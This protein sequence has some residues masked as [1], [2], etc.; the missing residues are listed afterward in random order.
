M[1]ILSFPIS[2]NTEVKILK[3]LCIFY[4]HDKVAL[5][6]IKIFVKCVYKINFV[7]LEEQPG[8]KTTLDSAQAVFISFDRL[9]ISLRNGDLYILTLFTDS[10]RSVKE[11]HFQ[12]AAASVLTTCVS[13]NSK[14]NIPSMENSSAVYPRTV[15]LEKLITGIRMHISLKSGGKK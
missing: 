13:S 11:F 1:K 8:I 14:Q 9:A 5:L 3:K 15:H 6:C 7:I 12:K 2:E 10:M 4:L